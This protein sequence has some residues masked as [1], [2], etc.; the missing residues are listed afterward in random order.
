MARIRKG[1]NLKAKLGYHSLPILAIAF[2]C[3]VLI[4]S[5]FRYG[6]IY[7]GGDVGLPTYDPN[8]VL[9]IVRNIWWEV[10]APGFPY[11]QSLSSISLYLILSGFQSLGLPSLTIQAGMFSALLFLM[12]IGM[13]ALFWNI[14]PQGSRSLA[15]LAAIFYL[16]NPYM[17]IQVWHRFVHTTFFLS[18]SLPLLM[19][20]FVRLIK[21]R[22]A[23][24]FV[25]FLITSLV[26]SYAYGSLAFMVTGWI[27]VGAY[28]L[29]E[30]W[31]EGGKG[32]LWENTKILV[33]LLISW[34]F[35]H[36]WWLF[37]F[38]TTGPAILT[39]QDS[40]YNS[41]ATL[42]SLSRQSIASLVL[43]GINPFYAF[44]ENAWVGGFD[45]PV[46]Q[47]ISWL[48][49]FIVLVGIWVVL[50]SR[51]LIFWAC[52]FILAV[53]LAK[54]GA[55]PFGHL[56][57][58]G[59]SQSFFLGAFRNPFEKLG[60]LV[61]FASAPLF[62]L[63]IRQLFDWAKA[64]IP[65]KQPIIIFLLG[66]ILVLIF[67]V[68][69]WPM[70]A[71]KIFGSRTET[72]FVRVPDEYK[73]ADKWLRDQK[74]SGRLLHL[75]FAPGD[76]I[77]YR[78][79]Y[80][81]SGVEPSQLLFTQPSISHGF[82]LEFLDGSLSAI[83]TSFRDVDGQNEVIA[84]V[85]AAL[86]VRY[87][88]LHKDV[89]WKTRR[90]DKPENLE[91]IL[92]D[93]PFLDK[94][95]QFGQLVIFELQDDF[96]SPRVFTTQQVHI[97]T[98]NKGMLGTW[99][100]LLEK[101]DV[102]VIF[103]SPAKDALSDVIF[104]NSLSYSAMPAQTVDIP[105]FPLAFKEN[106]AA[107]LPVPRFL[108]GS[109]LYPLVRIKE[110]I[111]LISTPIMSRYQA[112]LDLAGKRL[113]ESFLLVK[114]GEMDLTEEPL[115]DYKKSLISIFQQIAERQRGGLIDDKEEL[116]LKQIFARHRLVLE[117]VVDSTSLS[118]KK[119]A[120]ETLFDLN[121]GLSTLGFAP[122]FSL[123]EDGEMSLLGRQVF[124]FNLA[125]EGKFELLL[126]DNDARIL[127]PGNLERIP[128]QIDDRVE[129]RLGKPKGRFLS[130][131]ELNLSS[132]IHE[133]SFNLIDSVNLVPKI[134]T[135]G[136]TLNGK[137]SVGQEEGTSLFEINSG[138]H[139][140]AEISAPIENFDSGSLYQID[141]E[142]W[143]KKG[144]GPIL[145]IMQD[146][147]WEVKGKRFMEIDK[148]FDKGDYIFFW[149]PANIL[150]KPRPNSTEAVFR[151][152]IEPW[153]NCLSI[154]KNKIACQN[155]EIRKAYN[156][157]SQ[158]LIR[159][160]YVR[161]LLTNQVFLKSSF[162]QRKQEIGKVQ[163][164]KVS[165]SKLEGKL[166]LNGPEFLV[167]LETF[168]P[169]WEVFLSRGKEKMTLSEENHFLANG[170]GNLWYI[171]VPPGDY[172]LSIEFLPQKRFYQGLWLSGFG[173]AFI[174]IGLTYLRVKKKL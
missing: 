158:V 44:G 52:L 28:S 142:F 94:K 157:E 108:P 67:G 60:I 49:P 7:G 139:D 68:Y 123:I 12:G 164:S 119:T 114:E 129:I 124:K 74:K 147:D 162:E 10:H 11:P 72:P 83:S 138:V 54:G 61:P 58:W 17:M 39:Q 170:Y 102:P 107:E 5:W 22:K 64:K 31:V 41:I 172:H 66:V 63:G 26:S 121:K 167:F 89:D 165:P 169:G 14:F 42:T 29:Y 100:W 32:K 146:S 131:G 57:I 134:G 87:I 171:D 18:A 48:S 82:G 125:K 25:A 9:S 45:S 109:I 15:L 16:L 120:S 168:H 85:L 173:W 133:I 163:F 43:R 99:P 27:P 97:F 93:L 23:V 112:E 77:T 151:I 79:E 141:F 95:A 155:K 37:P 20:F 76:A 71:G 80:G 19:L 34:A 137:I 145:Q 3:G 160:I 92:T 159:N 128:F 33:L 115:T 150:F 122:Y 161:R 47:M 36:A 46:M 30:G 78:W 1:E 70:W 84:K 105:S 56:F 174:L 130:F 8:R 51:K 21:T 101:G 104:Q 156:R 6:L 4:I 35:I 118:T 135:Q 38:W 143:V 154:L 65:S 126:T 116:I 132:G 117:Q 110:G 140:S 59:F 73:Q 148:L 55:A 86:N 2:I 127:Y 24:W 153:N 50:K 144:Q 103:L 40:I 13:Y 106:A 136:W 53:F 62:A 98:S 149:N 90:L 96:F 166:T 113:V 91:K 88:I 111:T 81:Y 69:P 152:L 75:P